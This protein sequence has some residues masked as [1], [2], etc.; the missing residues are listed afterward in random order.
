MKTDFLKGVAV[1]GDWQVDFS[2]GQLRKTASQSAEKDA[3]IGRLEPKSCQVLAYLAAHAGA[4]V[5]KQDITE[6]VWS[7]S[8]ASDET[9]AR[10]I[11]R[12]RT[13]LG[14]DPRSPKYIETLPKRGYRLLAKVVAAPADIELGARTPEP[15]PRRP[16][17]MLVVGLL[18]VVAILSVVVANLNLWETPPQADVAPTDTQ[19]DLLARADDY[20][21]QMRLADNEMAIS[22]YQQQIE[23]NPDAALAYA[24]LANSLVQ[25]VIRWSDSGAAAAEPV[26][27]TQRVASGALDT[28]AAQRQLQRAQTLAE[29][30]VNLAPNNAAALK[31]LGFVRS[32]Q[33]DYAGAINVYEKALQVDE[34]AWQVWLNKGELNDAL[35]N[36][37]AALRDYQSAFQA[38]TKRYQANEVQ[39]RPWYADLGSFIG[40]RY[41]AAENY[42]EAE[43]WYRRVL[44]FAPVHEEATLGLAVVLQQTGDQPGALR[45]CEDLKRRLQATYFCPTKL[46]ERKSRAD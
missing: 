25:R 7:E 35:G 15:A 3:V 13:S 29:R 14:D 17:R 27:L 36:E 40:D 20:Y 46:A 12:L 34:S 5:S 42:Q 21:H 33:G 1:I 32:A 8:Y 9:I 16:R 31:A 30:A 39:I 37:A 44:A 11:S 28:E 24:G 45:L 41:L 26:T 22:L 2:S 6:A 18:L 43:S 23:L 38:M 19:D 4:L 10:T